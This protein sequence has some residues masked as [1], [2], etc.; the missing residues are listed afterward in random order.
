MTRW[1]VLFLFLAG[2]AYPSFAANPLTEAESLLTAQRTRPDAAQFE[3]AKEI[4]AAEVKRSPREPRVWILVA[5]ARMIEHRFAEALDAARAAERLAP[6]D[7]RALAL[8]SD[9]LV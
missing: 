5:W 9:A 7:A 4:A 1:V 6:G 3:R 8:A 2:L